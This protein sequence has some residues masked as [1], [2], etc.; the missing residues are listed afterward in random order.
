MGVENAW[1][2]ITWLCNFCFAPVLV[3]ALLGANPFW[4]KGTHEGWWTRVTREMKEEHSARRY[5]FRV[6][7]WLLFIAYLAAAAMFVAPTYLTHHAGGGND[8]WN[9][10]PVPLLFAEL[11]ILMT[12]TWLL[13]YLSTPS[14]L[15]TNILVLQALSTISAFMA[16]FFMLP[17][18]SAWWSL[19]IIIFNLFWAFK[20]YMEE[21]Y[22]CPDVPAALC[23]RKK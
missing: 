4:K 18:H 19:G 23:H 2:V 13:L 8:G 21:Q 6:P 5:P 1:V 16:F 3:S 11:T 14:S 15:C 9:V 17:R 20:V 22:R 12:N 10:D 7:L